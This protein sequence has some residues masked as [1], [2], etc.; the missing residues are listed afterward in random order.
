M[1]IDTTAALN[2]QYFET[3]DAGEVTGIAAA[4]SHSRNG[5]P[6][7]RYCAV[8]VRR[9]PGRAPEYHFKCY[10][11]SQEFAVH[12]RRATSPDDIADAQAFLERLRVLSSQSA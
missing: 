11:R 3:P 9:A 8:Y 4:L 1:K 5:K 2:A 7:L 6:F 10:R 12:W